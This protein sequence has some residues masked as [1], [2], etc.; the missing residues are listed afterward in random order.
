MGKFVFR[1]RIRTRE[2]VVSYPSFL[3][4]IYSATLKEMIVIN[5]EIKPQNRIIKFFR[6]IHDKAED[7]FFWIIQIVPEKFIPASLMTWA[8]HY[9]DK[10]IRQLK[11][12]TVRQN[13]NKTYLDQAVKEIQIRQQAKEKAPTEE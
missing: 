7:F 10:R 6:Q 2:N 3:Y 8:D 12:E 11:Q 4:T 1:D 5:I 9:L 13:W